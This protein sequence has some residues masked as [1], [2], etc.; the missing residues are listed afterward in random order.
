MVH[1]GFNTA[2]RLACVN[3]SMRKQITLSSDF[4]T[5]KLCK[6]IIKA[7][8]SDEHYVPPTA[9]GVGKHAYCSLLC[10]NIPS[11]ISRESM[12]KHNFCKTL[13][14]QNAVVTVNR[15]SR[16]LKSNSLFSVSKQLHVSMQVWCRKNLWFR[17]RAQKRL[18]LQ[19]F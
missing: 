16:S 13:K 19:F 18:N 7:V 15:R 6:C 17:R 11:I 8:F 12:Q 3:F 2:F 4:Q 14:L 9:I 5:F 1:I 10:Y